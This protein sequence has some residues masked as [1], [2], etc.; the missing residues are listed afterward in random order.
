M[1]EE[2]KRRKKKLITSPVVC[3]NTYTPHRI[4]NYNEQKKE[5]ETSRVSTHLK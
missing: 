3:I 5:N 1:R 4:D 2:K